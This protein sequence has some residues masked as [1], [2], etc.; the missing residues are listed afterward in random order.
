MEFLILNY[1]ANK[2]MVSAVDNDDNSFTAVDL[3]LMAVKDFSDESSIEENEMC[4]KIV[5][6]GLL[7]LRAL[8]SYDGKASR[9]IEDEDDA[10]FDNLLKNKIALEREIEYKKTEKRLTKIGAKKVSER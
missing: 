6:S 1:P 7:L 3:L 5:I 2:K 9:K 8:V 10:D 4:T